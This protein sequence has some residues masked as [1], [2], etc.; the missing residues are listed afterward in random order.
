MATTAEKIERFERKTLLVR[1]FSQ[2]SGLTEAAVY[3][4]IARGNLPAIRLGRT[5]LI[6]RDALKK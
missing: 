1:E 5:I 6:P 4:H 3:G 2:E